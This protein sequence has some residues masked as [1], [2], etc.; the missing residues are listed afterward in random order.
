MPMTRWCAM[1]AAGG[2]LALAAAGCQYTTRSSVSSTGA[3]GDGGS[4]FP[5]LSSDGRYAAFES[6]ATNLV[7]GDTNGVVDVFV[8]DHQTGTTSRVSR[9]SGGTQGNDR[10]NV[11]AI[12]ADGRYVAF[13]SSASN[14]VA[15]DTNGG[16]DVFVHDRQTGATTRVSVASDGAQGQGYSYPRPAISADGRYVAFVSDAGN[17]V[18]GDTNLRLDVFVR[19]RQILTTTR[20]SVSSAGAEGNGGSYDPAISGDG[21]IVAFTTD[22][23]NLVPGDTNARSDVVVRAGGTTSLASQSSGGAQGDQGATG[24]ALS[25]DGS[26]VAFSSHSTNL[27]AGDTNGQRDVFVRDRAGGTTTRVSLSSTAVQGNGQ[28]GSSGFSISADGRFVAFDSSAS[29]LVA[30]DTNSR[31]DVFVRDQIKGLTTRVST[32]ALGGQATLGALRGALSGDG[33]YAAFA[34]SAPLDPADTNARTD[35]YLKFLGEPK[36]TGIEP[37]TEKRGGRIDVTISGSGFEPGDQVAFSGGGVNVTNVVVV[38][39]EKI[40]ATFEILAGSQTGPRRVGVSRMAGGWNSALGSAGACEG[41][42][43]VQP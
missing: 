30:G 31:D 8:R 26:L 42:F 20:A 27:V 28:S 23:T 12:S 9:S 38:S 19:D 36:P 7:A 41:C 24:G 32:D 2:V 37:N 6:A 21:S 13:V 25:A 5:A 40:K 16:E 10:S 4:D 11:P 33:R 15:G 39:D 18:S 43:T 3:Q 34:S 1:A 29:N 35:I 17:L 22:A 14:L